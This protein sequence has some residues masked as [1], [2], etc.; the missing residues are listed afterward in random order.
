MINKNITASGI[1][2]T[3]KIEEYVEKR[4]SSISK[5]I[6]EDEAAQMNIKLSKTT[7][8]HLNGDVFRA[9]IDV[10]YGKNYFRAEAQTG[11]LYSSI[12]IAKDELV[13]EITKTKSKHIKLLKKGHQKIKNIIKRLGRGF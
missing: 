12:D 9:E 7:N 5:F 1:E 8:H 11:D 10:H 6:S 13:D 4:V 3:E 2:L